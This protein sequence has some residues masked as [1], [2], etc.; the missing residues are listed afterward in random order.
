MY[1]SSVAA[2]AFATF[3]DEVIVVTRED[4]NASSDVVAQFSDA[5]FDSII[6]FPRDVWFGRVPSRGVNDTILYLQ[7]YLND[8]DIVFFTG[9][10]EYFPLLA[11]KLFFNQRAFKNVEFF[12]VDYTSNH[13]LG[14]KHWFGVERISKIVGK[15]T[16]VSIL[17]HLF[18]Q[19][20]VFAMDERVVSSNRSRL[21]DF[22]NI[23]LRYLEDPHPQAI[24]IPQNINVEGY[25]F[26]LVGRQTSRKGLEDVAAALDILALRNV[27]NICVRLVGQ[28]VPETEKYRARLNALP[29]FLFS[30]VDDY[31][32]EEQIL[33]E[34]AVTDFV[35]LPYTKTFTG[36]S[37]VFA[38]SS[39]FGK[40]VLSTNHGCI[41]YRVDR[42]NCGFNYTS[43]HPAEL[44]ELI[45]KCSF[46]SDNEYSKLSH[47]MIQYSEKT[48][49]DAFAKT[50][51]SVVNER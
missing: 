42:F 12:M 23:R 9:F 41:G 24:F 10:N 4:F 11:L 31:L 50:I 26:L 48:S 51:E 16:L 6:T 19:L 28:L 15:L 44:A 47:S 7:K 22:F 8:K 32:S 45:Y 37:G 27:R 1:V 38:Y 33:K 21:V 17:S 5:R 36:S 35:I 14:F 3:T 49:E 2:Q 30:W 40:P 43:G 18:P 20:Q 13:Y 25:S 29:D 34:Y 46:I 39:A